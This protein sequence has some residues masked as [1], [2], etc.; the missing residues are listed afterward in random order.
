MPIN[1]AKKFINA[2]KSNQEL[3]LL[4]Y[5]V[6]PEG[7]TAFL[8]SKGYNF[9]MHEFED[10]LRQIHLSCQTEDSADEILQIA[11]WFGSIARVEFTNI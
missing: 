5:D 1:D 10:A 8:K 2:I 11:S 7:L 6:E 9:S 4:L 3:R